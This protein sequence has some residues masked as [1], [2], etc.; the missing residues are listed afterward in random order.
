M[1]GTLPVTGRRDQHARAHVAAARTGVTAPGSGG[2]RGGATEQTFEGLDSLLEIAPPHTVRA[3][4][5]LSVA[6]A[7][8]GRLSLAGDRTRPQGSSSASLAGGL[9]TEQSGSTKGPS[10]SSREADMKPYSAQPM[11]CMQFFS[12]HHYLRRQATTSGELGPRCTW[13]RDPPRV[14]RSRRSTCTRPPSREPSSSGTSCFSNC[15]NQTH[16]KPTLFNVRRTIQ[17]VRTCRSGAGAIHLSSPIRSPGS[18]TR[19]TTHTGAHRD[20]LRVRLC[21]PPPG[22]PLRGVG[23]GVRRRG[24]DAPRA[25]RL[26]V[27]GDE[28]GAEQ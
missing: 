13:A 23:R 15:D 11:S 10:P 26:G 4:Q 22:I 18:R 27:L 19:T 20:L 2:M 16:A 7:A 9:P 25:A 24:P 3:P 1:I 21:G 8:D 14:R 28:P 12:A 17:G 5:A 6:G